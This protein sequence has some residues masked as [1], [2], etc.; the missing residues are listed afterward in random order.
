MFASLNEVLL[1]LLLLII[2]II[3]IIYTITVFPGVLLV[4]QPGTNHAP[5]ASVTP[6]NLSV[7]IPSTFLRIRADPSMQIF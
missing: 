7:Q 3:I 1:L 4:H 5:G 6:V 2:I